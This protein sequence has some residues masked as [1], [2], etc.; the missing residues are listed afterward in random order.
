MIISQLSI[1]PLGKGTSVSEY[2]KIVVK[3]IEESGVKN[4]TNAMAT[5]IETKDIDTLFKVV[6]NAH[7]AMINA[8]AERVVTELKIDHRIDKNATSESKL[9]AIK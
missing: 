4:K 9:S 2:V 6:K 5:V 7:N 8:G 1:A 3:S